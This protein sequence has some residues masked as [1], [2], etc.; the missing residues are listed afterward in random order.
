MGIPTRGKV[1]EARLREMTEKMIKTL[2]KIYANKSSD[3]YKMHGDITASSH[4]STME[5]LVND[6]STL[7]HF[8]SGEANDIKTMFL[9][10]HRPIWKKMVTEYIAKPDERNTAYTIAFT[11]GY[12]LLRGE[13]ARIYA[14]T[15]ATEKGIV[16]KP[17]KIGRR[18]FVL[19]YIRYYNENLD[20]LI[21]DAIRRVQKL[22]PK[23]AVKQEA[24][25][26]IAIDNII[27]AAAVV[28]NVLGSVFKTASQ[29]N[30]ISFIS[31]MLSRSYDKT[32]DKY[33]EAAAMYIASKDA[34]EEYKK[35]P[36][37]DR[38]A[39]IESKYQK[40][41]EKYNIKMKNLQAKIDHFDSRSHEETNDVYEGRHVDSDEDDEPKNETKESPKEKDEDTSSS[42]D[43]DNGGFDF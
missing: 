33:E 7:K 35:L 37:G 8:P 28:F 6:L 40:N 19:R 23:N 9:T 26:A 18:E 14:S 3:E 25:V 38:K 5:R 1:N 12:R 10:L 17:G 27:D 20:K 22:K 41:I 13:L 2:A 39:K 24:A 43:D 42:T 16:Y 21:E 29:L 36:A 11:N 15:E 32:I 31:G 4:Y 30:P 34:Y